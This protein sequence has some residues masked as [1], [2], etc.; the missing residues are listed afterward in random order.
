M[1]FFLYLFQ[2]MCQQKTVSLDR[3]ERLAK[4]YSS[5]ETLSLPETSDLG[6]TQNQTDTLL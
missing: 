3:Q 2:K 4:C 5:K 6:I 1:N